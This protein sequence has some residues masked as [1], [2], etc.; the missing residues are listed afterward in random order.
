MNENRERCANMCG[1]VAVIYDVLCSLVVPYKLRAQLATVS[2]CIL[3][4]SWILSQSSLLSKAFHLFDGLRGRSEI[5]EAI[6]G[7]VDVV[8]NPHTSHAPVPL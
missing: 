5:L 2:T 7:N 1:R 8:F 4:I 3:N 6:L